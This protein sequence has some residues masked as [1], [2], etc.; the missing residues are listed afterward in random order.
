MNL[1]NF[2]SE[3]PNEDRCKLLLKDI[4]DKLGVICRKCGGKEHYWKKDKWQ[5][6][7][8][9]CK[10]RTTLTSGTVMHGS[11]L[12][13]QYWVIAMELI[14]KGERF[15]VAELQKHLG[16]KHYDAIWTMLH[17][18]RLTIKR[19]N[20]LGNTKFYK[21]LFST[22]INLED[23]ERRA[24]KEKMMELF[25]ADNYKIDI[26]EKIRRRQIKKNSESLDL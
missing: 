17:K 6:E 25:L 9:I 13:V 21:G 10:T 20:S 4:R 2:I 12:P 24:R 16:H 15:S 11:Q 3:Y 22:K 18:L 14:A 5:Y 23:K 1:L 19:Y 8:K 26:T 7:C